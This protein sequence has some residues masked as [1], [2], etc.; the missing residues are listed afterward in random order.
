MEKITV[1]ELKRLE[2]QDI[3]ELRKDDP[4][5]AAMLFPLSI[6]LA[7]KLHRHPVSNHLW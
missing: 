1:E 5:P 2:D 7:T 3:R 6:S 4:D